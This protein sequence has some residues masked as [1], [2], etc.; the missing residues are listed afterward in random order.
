MNMKP[1][2]TTAQQHTGLLSISSSHPYGT[3]SHK[4]EPSVVLPMDDEKSRIKVALDKLSFL[5]TGWDGLD[6]LPVSKRVLHNVSLILLTSNNQDWKNWT[7]EPNINGTVLLRSISRKAGIS[8]GSDTFSYYQ[9]EDGNITG[10]DAVDF[11]AT[12]VLT[13]MRSSNS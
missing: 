8:I 12:A 2:V 13:V 3:H 4:G 7:I 5:K 10:K 1:N 11:S 6:A 9:K